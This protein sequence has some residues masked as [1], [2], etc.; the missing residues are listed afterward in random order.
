LIRLDQ[1]VPGEAGKVS[2]GGGG[3]AENVNQT[4]FHPIY[5]AALRP[6]HVGAFGVDLHPY[7]WDYTHE[8]TPHTADMRHPRAT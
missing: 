1:A 7:C 6:D 4:P 8:W 3:G 5:Y 2:R